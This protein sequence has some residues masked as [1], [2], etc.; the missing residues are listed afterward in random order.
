VSAVHGVQAQVKPLNVLHRRV[1]QLICLDA[2]PLD[3]V[4]AHQIIHC[5]L[6]PGVEQPAHAHARHNSPLQ[7]LLGLGEIRLHRRRPR[8]RQCA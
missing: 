1:T 7:Q 3:E 8:S 2:T 6:R 4:H 5:S